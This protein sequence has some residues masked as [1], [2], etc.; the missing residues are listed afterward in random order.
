MEVLLIFLAIVML[1]SIL[2]G[3]W[4]ARWIFRIDD[5]CD[6]LLKIR[7]ILELAN[8]SKISEGGK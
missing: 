6:E 5:I 4:I 1:G 8:Y 3:V 2:L 7:K